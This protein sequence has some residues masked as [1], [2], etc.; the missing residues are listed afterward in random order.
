MKATLDAHV[1]GVPRS[2]A[3]ELS[4]SLVITAYQG[5]RV[6]TKSMLHQFRLAEEC[7][8]VHDSLT[9]IIVE[10][11]YL[12]KKRA[13]CHRKGSFAKYEGVMRWGCVL[14]LSVRP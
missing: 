7:P 10:S 14:N 11:S 6:V 5:H 3:K 9:G 13:I 12:S 4:R 2:L 1:P 8:Q